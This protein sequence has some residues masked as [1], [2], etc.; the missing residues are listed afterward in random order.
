MWNINKEPLE[1]ASIH[2]EPLGIPR[3]A[4]SV[5]VIITSTEPAWRG[6]PSG[7]L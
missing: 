1:P 4:G 6:M 3:Q 2:S 7:S 5:M